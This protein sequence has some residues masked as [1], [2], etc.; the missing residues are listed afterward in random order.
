MGMSY[1]MMS[2]QEML[3][4]LMEM[5]EWVTPEIT[6]DNYGDLLENEDW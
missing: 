6:T 2:E 1:G 5:D 3:M 4:N